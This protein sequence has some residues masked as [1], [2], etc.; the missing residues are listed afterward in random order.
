MDQPGTTIVQQLQALTIIDK[1]TGW[2]EFVATQS[3]TSQQVAILFDGAWLCRYP[4]PD[5]VVFDNGGEFIGAEFQELLASYGIKPVPTTVR[6]P[7]SNGVIERVHL[8]MGDMLRTITF[9]GKDWMPEAQR[10]LDVVAW[11]I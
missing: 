8:T 6:N 10:T 7:K 1:G 9:T 3:K 5:R 2:P 11:A 4:R